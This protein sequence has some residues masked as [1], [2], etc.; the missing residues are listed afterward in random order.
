MDLAHIRG[1]IQQHGSAVYALVFGYAATHNLLLV[2]FAGYA[3]QMAAL[4]WLTLVLVRRI[5]ARYGRRSPRPSLA[6]MKASHRFRFRTRRA[7][8][9]TSGEQ[10]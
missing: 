3:A 2:L 8:R 10:P 5:G 1:L 4:D 6:L 7:F 9:H